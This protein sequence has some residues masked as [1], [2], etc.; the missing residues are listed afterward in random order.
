MSGGVTSHVL[1]AFGARR[2]ATGPQY[3]R[4]GGH[5]S[6]VVARSAT[7]SR[8]SS[9]TSAPACAAYGDA[10]RRREFH[11]TVLLSHLHWDHVQGLPFFAPLHHPGATLDVYGPR[12]AEGPLGDVF[13]QTDAAAVLPDPARPI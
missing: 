8:R 7:A 10:A 9:S 3:A 2:R 13:A 5:S 11:G 4:Y 6:C 1:T 12:Q